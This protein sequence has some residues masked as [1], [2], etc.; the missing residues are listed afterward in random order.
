MTTL[1]MAAKDFL[2]QRRIAV[3]GVSATRELAGNNIYKRFRDRGTRCSRS[4]RMP[5]RCTASDATRT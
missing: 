4:T 3:A 1:Q 2:A 5:R